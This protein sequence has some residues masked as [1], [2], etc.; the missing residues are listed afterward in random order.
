MQGSSAAGSDAAD[1][2]DTQDRV[3]E[4]QRV[5]MENQDPSERAHAHLELGR[6]ALRAGR[7]EQAVR[8]LREALHHEPRLDAA[9]RLLGDLGEASA[10]VR[11]APKG[12]RR[13]AV[14]DLLR[15]F[16]RG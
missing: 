15:G 13:K 11:A 10:L 6:I 4:L 9:R 16:R 7:F 3:A 1:A 8:H 12:S 14:H 2:G 5:L